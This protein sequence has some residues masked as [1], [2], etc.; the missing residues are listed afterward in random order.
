[1][2]YAVIDTNVLVSALFAVHPDSA[3]VIV[4]DK[5]AAGDIVPLYNAE[6]LDEYR[7]VLSRPK[8]QFPS[9]HIDAVLELILQKGISLDRTKSNESFPDPKDVVFYEVALSKDG[10]YLVTGNIKHFPHTP[11]VVTP[12][13]L[14]RIID[15]Q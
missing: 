11:I 2:V 10:S 4:R 3:T 8:F 1:M 9:A 5:I 15:S 12:S 7:C 14:L 13:E 6:I